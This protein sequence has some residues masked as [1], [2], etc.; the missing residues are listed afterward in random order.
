MT[1]GKTH[2]SHESIIH[3]ALRRISR[4]KLGKCS[5]RSSRLNPSTNQLAGNICINDRWTFS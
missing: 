5:E 1:V 2:Q 4:S 3:Q